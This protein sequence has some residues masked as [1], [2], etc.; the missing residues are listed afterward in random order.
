V[1]FQILQGPLGLLSPLEL[2]LV[3]QEFEGSTLSSSREM[4]LFRAAIHPISFYTSLIVAGASILVMA[5]I[6]TGL[7]SIP[8][9]LTMNPSNFPDG[10]PKMN[11]VGLSFHRNLRKLLNVSSKSAIRLSGFLVTFQVLRS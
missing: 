2:V 7:S 3:F 11:F 10:T 4:N 1:L 5:M 6:F 8:R 9:L